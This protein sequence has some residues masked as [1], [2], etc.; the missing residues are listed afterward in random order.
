MS[1]IAFVGFLV[2]CLSLANACDQPSAS[3]SMNATLDFSGK[4]QI[5][6]ELG[7]GAFGSVHLVQFEKQLG[8]PVAMKILHKERPDEHGGY[9]VHDAS[10]VEL[11]A[12]E[13]AALAR[14]RDHPESFI[15]LHGVFGDASN[16]YIVTRC[17]LLDLFSF[18]EHNVWFDS[19]VLRS[20]SWDVTH[21]VAYLHSVNIVHRDLKPENVMVRA[22]G[23]AVLGDFGLCLMVDNPK[24]LTSKVQCGSRDFVPPEM[25]D[26][27][28]YDGK[29]DV[30][31]VGVLLYF[32]ATHMYPFDMDHL[33]EVN[34][35]LK[36][37]AQ[38]I[39]TTTIKMRSIQG[40]ELAA[41]I[42]ATLT[43]EPEERPSST[44]L[45]MSSW[46]S[47]VSETELEEARAKLLQK[48]HSL[49]QPANGGRQQPE[50]ITRQV[51]TETSDWFDGILG[52]RGVTLQP[53]PWQW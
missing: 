11:F 44:A 19:Q 33:D 24:D 7:K 49:K 39:R 34:C 18:C 27:L 40:N 53:K 38:I 9:Q 22:D 1:F 30:W 15:E 29:A 48:A 21:A 25:A 43:V 46:I 20:I 31:A 35:D 4:A 36:E 17:E 8:K 51:G 14:I 16:L 23:R 12:A 41:F 42:K 5:V 32:A 3:A 6:R 2:L 47:G 52:T 10:A 13:I 45:L 37:V 28:E 26:G 50:V